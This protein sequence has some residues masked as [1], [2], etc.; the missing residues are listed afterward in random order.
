VSVVIINIFSVAVVQ[1]ANA[2]VCF[3][4]NSD[5][6]LLLLLLCFTYV[7][8]DP[9]IAVVSAAVSAGLFSQV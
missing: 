3:V 4:H 2:A 6:S 5:F 8:I 9:I 7:L 1:G